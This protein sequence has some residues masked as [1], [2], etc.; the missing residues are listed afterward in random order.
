MLTR[1]HLKPSINT[2]GGRS[3]Y[4]LWTIQVIKSY[5]WLDKHWFVKRSDAGFLIIR[6]GRSGAGRPADPLTNKATPRAVL[7]GAILCPSAS[8]EGDR[9]WP[10]VAGH[11][12]VGGAGLEERLG[13]GTD[14]GRLPR[15]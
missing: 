1:H 10:S 7:F 11:I 12:L 3:Y 2:A 6:P 14:R 9:E 5:K 13:L 15:P 8:I 4:H